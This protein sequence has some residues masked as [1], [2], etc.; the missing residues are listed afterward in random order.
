MTEPAR[1]MRGSDQRRL[2]PVTVHLEETVLRRLSAS[3]PM[4]SAN[5]NLAERKRREK[6]TITVSYEVRDELVLRKRPK[7]D[8]ETVLRRLLNL[9]PTD[10]DE[11]DSGD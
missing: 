10:A 3:L 2:F 5:P 6:T 1:A 9:E 11:T 7:E 4:S 8:Y